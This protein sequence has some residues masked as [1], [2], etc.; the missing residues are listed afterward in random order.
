MLLK[1]NLKPLEILR[2][3]FFIFCSFN[4]K[5]KKVKSQRILNS[6]TMKIPMGNKKR[7][8]CLKKKVQYCEIEDLD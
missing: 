1:K 8:K 6:S 3:K 7:K 2:W 4:F 5:I